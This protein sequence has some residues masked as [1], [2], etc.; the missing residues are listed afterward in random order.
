MFNYTRHIFRYDTTQPAWKNHTKIAEHDGMECVADIT[1]TGVLDVVH[2]RFDDGFETNAY[3][4]E[5][6]AK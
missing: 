6:E 2:I 1:D 3:V 5:L 4:Y